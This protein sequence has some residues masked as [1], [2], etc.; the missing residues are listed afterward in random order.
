MTRYFSNIATPTTLAAGINNTDV[1][2]TVAVSD[3]LTGWPASRP[4]TAIIDK[5]TANEEMVLV[6][7]VNGTTLT[8]TRGVHGYGKYA[9]SS[10]ATFVHAASAQDLADFQNHIDVTLRPTYGMATR[11]ATQSMAHLTWYTVAFNNF[12]NEYVNGFAQ[13]MH[14]GTDWVLP[15]TGMWTFSACLT[16]PNNS[17]YW[18]IKFTDS[19]D[20][21][22]AQTSR[23]PFYNDKMSLS[24]S[25]YL[26]SGTH[27]LLKVY[28]DSAGTVT[29]PGDSTQAPCYFSALLST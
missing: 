25:R 1:T 16:V 26:T 4:Y 3:V 2:S 23:N 22:L 6:T 11:T 24:C 9:H 15:Y 14:S 17:A 28:Q 10:G 13:S 18:S 29:L 20:V 21:D 5:D 19:N 27:V 8:V 7:V 12:T